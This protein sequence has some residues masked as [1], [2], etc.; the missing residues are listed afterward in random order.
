MNVGSDLLGI[1]PRGVDAPPLGHP[2]VVEGASEDARSGIT[3]L[4]THHTPIILDVEPRSLLGGCVDLRHPPIDVDERGAEVAK[5]EVATRRRDDD[6][7]E[8]IPNGDVALE[9]ASILDHQHPV[10]VP[11]GA[12][13]HLFGDGH[14]GGV[15]KG[16]LGQE[17]AI[18]DDAAVDDD[19][20]RRGP[21]DVV[22]GGDDVVA[23]PARVNGPLNPLSHGHRVNGAHFVGLAR[24]GPADDER[25]GGDEAM[26]PP[27]S[28][29]QHLIGD[30]VGHP[31]LAVSRQNVGVADFGPP[32]LCWKHQRTIL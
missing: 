1:H 15:C 2:L 27:L 17:T 23:H 3:S 9:E 25:V 19:V 30:E 26:L 4:R 7:A 31:P 16:G 28:L 22:R 20:R 12:G 21:H 8:L 18:S 6:V 13:T 29:P 11:C 5:G 32:T 14:E 10:V 24:F